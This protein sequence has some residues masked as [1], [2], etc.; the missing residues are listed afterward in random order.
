MKPWCTYRSEH[1]SGFY[2]EG[3]GKTD[4]VAAGEYKGSGIRFKLSLELPEFAWDTWTTT[5]LETFATEAEAYAAEELLVPK[6]SLLDPF[7]LNM[8]AGGLKGKYQGHSALF[9]SIN[10]QKRAAA[11]AVKAEKAREKKAKEAAKLKELKAK[12]KAKK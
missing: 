12:L 9:R 7:R 5:I 11:K 8:T 2:Y 3:K 6:E 10:S 1:P 4:K